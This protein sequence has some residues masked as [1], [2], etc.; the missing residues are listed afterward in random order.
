MKKLFFSLFTFLLISISCAAQYDVKSTACS[1]YENFPLRWEEAV[2]DFTIDT[3]NDQIIV[4][5][6]NQMIIFDIVE[7]K[8]TNN[9]VII[10][11]AICNSQGKYFDSKLVAVDGR[12]YFY[13]EY[14]KE[15]ISFIYNM[16]AEGLPRR[17]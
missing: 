12:L 13:I 17:L 16:E 10:F 3:V 7:Y 6:I 5:P 9:P 4:E 14:L 1:M 15:N 2:A 8:T 11:S